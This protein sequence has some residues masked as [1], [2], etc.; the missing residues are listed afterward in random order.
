MKKYPENPEIFLKLPI[1]ATLGF[2]TASL[3]QC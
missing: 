2:F 3:T 1:W